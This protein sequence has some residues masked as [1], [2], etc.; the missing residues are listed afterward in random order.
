MDLFKTGIVD[1]L[2][3]IPPG[4]K[5]LN[6]KVERSHRIDEQYFYWTAPTDTIEN[7]NEANARWLAVYNT[8]RLHGGIEYR[9]PQEKLLERYE[10]LRKHPPTDENQFF[11]KRFTKELP[12]R[13]TKLKQ[14][15]SK[16]K[17]A[18]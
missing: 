9:T 5:E 7:F 12:N 11:A 4:E 3:C 14:A 15:A 17:Q 13:F 18:A 2:R 16:L 8:E 1:D 10:T 6:G